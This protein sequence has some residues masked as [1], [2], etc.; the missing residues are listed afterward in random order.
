M[1]ISQ[2]QVGTVPSVASRVFW[3][4]ECW[5]LKRI[6]AWGVTFIV[7]ALA[8]LIHHAITIWTCLLLLSIT[9]NYWLGYWLNDYF[10]A[11]HDRTD[12]FKASQNLFVQRPDARKQ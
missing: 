7:C 8:L 12:A 3:Y 1:T 11:A 5:G 2:N 4:L 6:D 10:D 9:A